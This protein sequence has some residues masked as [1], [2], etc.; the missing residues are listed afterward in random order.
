MG[1]REGGKEEGR[2]GVRK[3]GGREG[4]RE[5]GSRWGMGMAGVCMGPL[6]CICN[7][8]TLFKNLSV[9]LTTQRISY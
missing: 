2:E 6:Q 5:G 4:E 7:C 3:E 9:Y 8:C 1:G